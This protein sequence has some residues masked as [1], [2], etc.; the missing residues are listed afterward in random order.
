MMIS[1][2]SNFSTQNQ[3]LLTNSQKRT[4]SKNPCILGIFAAQFT[5]LSK[6]TDDWLSQSSYLTLIDNPHP[7][8]TQLDIPPTLSN[9]A[10]SDLITSKFPLHTNKLLNMSTKQ[11]DI[12]WADVYYSFF[13]LLILDRVYA[14]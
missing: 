3:P 4:E 14:G 8:A 1:F 9:I 13:P 12:K 11:R 7:T 6:I 2:C 5:E 10:R